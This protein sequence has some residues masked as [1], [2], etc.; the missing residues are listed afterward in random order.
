MNSSCDGIKQNYKK[1]TKFVIM[2][3]HLALQK[4]FVDAL[5]YRYPTSEADAM[6]RILVEEFPKEKDL[7]EFVEDNLG[8]LQR[9][10]P[11]QYVLGK[12]YFYGINLSVSESVLI[13][14]PETEELVHRIIKDWSRE[15]PRIIDIGTGSGCIALAL[16]K[17]L[18]HATVYAVDVSPDALAV[19]R[20]N[21]SDLD[22]HVE[23]MLADI[24]EWDVVMDSSLKFD[25]GVSNPP[26]ITPKEREDMEEHV[27]FYEPDIALFAPE[28]SPL[29]FYQ[30]IADFALKHLNDH[31]K[32]Y[33]EIN[34]YFG[35]EVVDLLRKKG[36]KN[37]QLI[38][39]MQGADRM[40]EV[41]KK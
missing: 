27:L 34:R 21:A 19:A 9:G 10:R 33:F 24:L 1:N 11:F 31:G 5:S 32:L 29:L 17:N 8:D 20:Q 6:F 22:L 15:A 25:V 2:H 13:P 39:D 40:V 3:N 12:A 26:Y 37:V 30:H 23:F 35:S 36:F 7:I 14:R 18:P 28:E 41:S 38:Q 16:K 4:Q